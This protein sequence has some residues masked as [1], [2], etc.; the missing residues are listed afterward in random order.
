[1]VFEPDG[2]KISCWR[3]LSGTP[4]PTTTHFFGSSCLHTG[5]LRTAGRGACVAHTAHPGL[6]LVVSGADSAST[7]VQYAAEGGAVLRSLAEMPEKR[8]CHVMASIDK[9]KVTH[10]R[11]YSMSFVSTLL[12]VGNV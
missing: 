6:G 7:S 1:M 11:V 10:L 4:P 9:G 5:Q 12:S 8:S 2:C 3:F